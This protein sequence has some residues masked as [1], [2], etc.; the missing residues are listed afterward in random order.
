MWLFVTI[1]IGFLIIIGIMILIFAKTTHQLYGGSREAI[2]SRFNY[3]PEFP[4]IS[5]LDTVDLERFSKVYNIKDPLKFTAGRP[6]RYYHTDHSTWV[7][8]W[9]FPQEIQMRCIKEASDKCHEPIIMI[10]KEEDKLSGL[11]VSNPKDIVRV[12]DCYNKVYEQ[13]Q[14]SN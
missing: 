11:A 13:C 5:Q 6:Y 10:K 9:D 8:P 4:F 12:S 3:I 2:F 14:Q 7:Y 1:T